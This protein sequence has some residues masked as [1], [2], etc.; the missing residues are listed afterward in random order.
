MVKKVAGTGPKGRKEKLKQLA[1]K[2]LEANWMG[3][4]ITYPKLKDLEKTGVSPPQSEI[5]WRAPG[6]ETRPEPQ[7]GEVIVFADHITWGFR[8]PGLASSEIY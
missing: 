4:E 1:S 6:G 8:P 2:T 5:K 7:Q 3:S